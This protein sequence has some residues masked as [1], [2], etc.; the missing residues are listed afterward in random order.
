MP[1]QFFRVRL[2]DQK[3]FI[4]E[5]L[6]QYDKVDGEIRAELPFQGIWTLAGQNEGEQHTLGVP[7]PVA[8]RPTQFFRVGS[9]APAS[10]A[11]N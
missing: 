2:W 8:D 7:A 10:P 9:V 6:A 1:A 3:V 4:D 11:I 5:L